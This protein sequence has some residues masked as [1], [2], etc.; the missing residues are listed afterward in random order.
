M[1]QPRTII[2]REGKISRKNASGAT[3]PKNSVVTQGAGDDLIALPASIDDP[4]LG[5]VGEADILNGEWGDII[6]APG[7]VVPCK[8]QG[9]VTRG[10]RLA[11]AT[12]GDAGKVST[13]AP[14]GG[15]NN[16]L[17]GIAMRTAAD[18]EVFE[19][20]FAGPAARIQG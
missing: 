9:A 8:A 5:V 12:G 16:S 15:T 13:A 19:V 11:P 7:S 6:V 14:A 20:L 2:Q 3:I 18:E 10:Q 4:I 1:P 17:V